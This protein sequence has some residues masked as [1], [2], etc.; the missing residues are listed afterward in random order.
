MGPKRGVLG[1]LEAVPAD[2][3]LGSE[4]TDRFASPSGEPDMGAI[5]FEWVYRNKHIAAITGLLA[6]SGPNNAC[7][8]HDYG[9]Y[10]LHIDGGGIVGIYKID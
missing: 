5:G 6:A 1:L 10:C 7:A 4:Q 2:P 8:G 9:Y 3:S